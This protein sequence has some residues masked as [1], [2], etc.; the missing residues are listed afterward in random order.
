VQ[1]ARNNLDKLLAGGT[2]DEI[3]AASAAVTSAK[4]ALDTAQ[5]NWDR[6]VSGADLSQRSE[7]TALVQARADYQTALSTYNTKIAPP[8]QGDVDAAR[9]NV[10]SANASVNAALAKLAQVQ[11]GALPTD[12]GQAREAVN[13][14][15]LALN[16]AQYDVDN[17]VLKAPMAGTVVAVGINPGDQVGASTAAF[18]LLDPTM[19]RI[20]ATVDE[21]SVIK[22][23]P[24]MPVTVTFDALQGR[25]F[26]GI[27]AVVTPAGVTQQG[28]VTFPVTVMFNTQGYTVPPGTTATLRI[29][30]DS[31]SNVLAV[32]SRAIVRAGGATTV[33]VPEDGKPVS[34]TIATGVT[35]DTYVEVTGGLSEG[36]TFIS[37]PQAVQSGG[38]AQ[39]GG[40]FGA[41]GLPGL[42]TG[43]PASGG[44]RPAGR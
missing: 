32:P 38:Q 36:D 43:A 33:L 1:T 6:L 26:Q 29:V 22:L 23:K 35:G 39:T 31:K 5:T 40:A 21:S 10:D 30:T 27:V 42:G 17:A 3:A 37:N 18:T 14:A 11:G 20:D 16:Q 12:I 34:H 44:A 15:E 7:Y 25:Q 13:T 8:K 24:G 4:A 28:V 19:L 9:A 41:G 2:Q